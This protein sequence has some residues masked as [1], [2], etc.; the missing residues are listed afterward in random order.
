MSIL[1]YD[2]D[3]VDEALDECRNDKRGWCVVIVV[4]AVACADDC[5]DFV[6]LVVLR[7]GE[8]TGEGAVLI[9]CCCCDDDD[10]VGSW[11]LADADSDADVLIEEE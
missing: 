4:I 10:D 11:W 8:R 1:L 2:D 7:D 9:L 5:D 3:V 6:D